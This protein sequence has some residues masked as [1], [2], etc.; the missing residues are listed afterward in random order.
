MNPV[1]YVVSYT[2]ALFYYV[3]DNSVVCWRWASR[4]ATLRA[5]SLCRASSDDALEKQS[6]V[7]G[8]SG[9]GGNDNAVEDPTSNQQLETVCLKYMVVT[10]PPLKTP[11]PLPQTDPFTYLSDRKVVTGENLPEND[12]VS[13][14][15][16]GCIQTQ[17]RASSALVGCIQTQ[18]RA[19][20]ALVGCIQTQDRASSALVGCIQTQDRAS[21]ALVGCIQ[22]Q[23]RASSA[24]VGCIQAQ[25]RAS[26]A[27][28]GCIQTQDRASSALVGCF[29]TQDRASSGLVGCIQTQDRASSALVGW[30]RSTDPG[31]S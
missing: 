29:Q 21:L 9:I 23:D 13:S 20:S 10:F 27:L 24:L 8:T 7:P 11:Q 25:D 14:A 22:T 12:R 15:L 3:R 5:Y 28:V 18:D 26:S 30:V 17:D 6:T 2:R 4:E 31:Q 16:V 1:Q 19:S